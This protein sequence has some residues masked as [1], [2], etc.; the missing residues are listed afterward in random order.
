MLLSAGVNMKKIYKFIG[1]NIT[2]RSPDPIIRACREIKKRANYKCGYRSRYISMRMVKSIIEPQSL[3]NNTIRIPFLTD[4]IMEAIFELYYEVSDRNPIPDDIA[5]FH[6]KLRRQTFFNEQVT[7]FN[8]SNWR[9][10][11]TESMRYVVN[12][13][14]D[15]LNSINAALGKNL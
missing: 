8:E 10:Q 7:A 3:S 11:S 12:E 4:R 2:G 15:D 1:D 13:L 14:H 9:N 5:C 6:N